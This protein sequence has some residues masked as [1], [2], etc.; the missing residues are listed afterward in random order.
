MEKNNISLRKILDILEKNYLHNVWNQG[1]H[2]L[3]VEVSA[4]TN[5]EYWDVIVENK[6]SDR[7]TFQF[8]IKEDYG[9]G[10]YY[11]INVFKKNNEFFIMAKGL[12]IDE[13][14]K[15]LNK[16]DFSNIFNY[17]KNK[18]PA[19]SKSE[20]NLNGIY[21]ANGENKEI[22][23]EMMHKGVNISSSKKF[24]YSGKKSTDYYYL[25]YSVEL[26]K[27]KFKEVIVEPFSYVDFADIKGLYVTDPN[28]LDNITVEFEKLPS[29]IQGLL[30]SNNFDEQEDDVADFSQRQKFSDTEED[31]I[32][33]RDSQEESISSSQKR[34]RHPVFSFFRRQK[35]K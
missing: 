22:F 15:I 18:I 25:S 26:G 2:D 31:I 6:Y 7:L 5:Y 8:K 27:M 13:Q 10:S 24:Y 19:F 23:I 21:N 30:C 17:Y 4:I 9:F 32:T 16:I 29:D 14:N 3:F 33:I 20:Y 1:L 12:T 35:K 34:T 28:F 11:D